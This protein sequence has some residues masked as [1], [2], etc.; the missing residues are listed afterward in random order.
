MG[1]KGCRKSSVIIVD[2]IVF[3]HFTFPHCLLQTLQDPDVINWTDT[4]SRALVLVRERKLAKQYCLKLRAH[5]MVEKMKLRV[6]HIVGHGKGA[7]DGGMD[8][9][10]QRKVFDNHEKLVCIVSWQ[11]KI[12]CVWYIWS[13]QAKL[14][15]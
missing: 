14:F 9:K 11:Q 5:P 13:N 12:F 4:S 10:K 6:G 2:V 15:C 3:K 7:K 8:V 1:L